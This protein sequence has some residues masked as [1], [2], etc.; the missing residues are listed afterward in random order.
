MYSSIRISWCG[1]WVGVWG[2]KS[3][4]WVSHVVSYGIVLVFVVV[5]K[6]SPAVG[7]TG[8]H[9]DRQR[10]IA[11]SHGLCPSLR[12]TRMSTKPRGDLRIHEGRRRPREI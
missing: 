9:R 8:S 3:S 5:G 6:G 2:R 10:D 12:V 7:Y 11:T 4:R 1:H